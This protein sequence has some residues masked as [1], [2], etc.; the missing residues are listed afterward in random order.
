MKRLMFACWILAMS[1]CG[2]ENDISGPPEEITFAPELGIDLSAMTKTA[3]GTYYQDLVVGTGDEVT[4]GTEI[5]VHY[6][7]WLPNGVRFDS[8]R[9]PG[10]GPFLWTVGEPGIILGWSDG[11]PGMHVGGVRLLVI[12]PKNAYGEAGSPPTIPGN[13]TLIFEIEVLEIIPGQP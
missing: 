3:L 5:L 12:P 10:R 7:G 4:A 8:S 11:V 6:S 13:T 1:A 9:N 2:S